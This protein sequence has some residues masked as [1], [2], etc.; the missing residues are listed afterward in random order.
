M[1]GEDDRESLVAQLHELGVRYLTPSAARVDEAQRL[2]RGGL[3]ARLAAHPDPRLRRALIALFILHPEAADKAHDLALTLDAPARVELI[4]H[5]LAA[6]YLQRMWQT[7]LG[8]YR[9]I[10]LLPDLFSAQQGLP[11]PAE[12]FGQTGLRALAHW[13]AAQTMLPYN[14]LASYEAVMNLLFEQL[15]QESTQHEPA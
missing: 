14:Y 6:V 11:S 8:F 12:R 15:K 10:C 13:H 5:Y 3:I 4:A 9:P 2:T 1:S 7:R